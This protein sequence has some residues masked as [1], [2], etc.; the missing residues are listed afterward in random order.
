MQ[1]WQRGEC[2]HARALAGRTAVLQSE[3]AAWIRWATKNMGDHDPVSGATTFSFASKRMLYF[4]MKQMDER[5]Q[6]FSSLP[7]ESTFLQV[8]RTFSKY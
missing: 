7:A 1:A 5:Q 8:L 3:T 2:N 6:I 4:C